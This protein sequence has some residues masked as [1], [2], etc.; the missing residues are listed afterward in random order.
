M[1]PWAD[2]GSTTPRKSAAKPLARRHRKY[3]NANREAISARRAK[4]YKRKR[5]AIKAG[6][7]ETSAGT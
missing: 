7:K 6:Q 3:Y 4:G 2:P 1:Q 5:A